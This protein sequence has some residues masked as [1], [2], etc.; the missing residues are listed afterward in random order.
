[1][2]DTYP[3]SPETVRQFSNYKLFD[4]VTPINVD[5]LAYL[6][7]ASDYDSVETEFL[8]DGF[9]QGFKLG[10]QGPRDFRRD[11]HNLRFRV[12]NKY[13]LWDKIMT[14]VQ[15]KRY[16]GP[17]DSPQQIFPDCYSVN[18]C[19]LVSKSGNRT[20]LINHYSYPPGNS[21]NDFIPDSYSKVTYQDFQEAITISL[22]LLKLGTA[23]NPVDLHYT[24]TDAK[25]V[26]RVLPIFWDDRRFQLLKAENP[27]SGKMQYFVD[28]CCGFGSSSSC[29][30]YSKISSCLRHLY[31]HQAG[32]D[33]VVYLDDGLQIG[34]NRTNAN[35]NLGIYLGICKEINLPISKEKTE[36]ATK[37]IKF[38]GLLINAIKNTVEVPADKVLKALN[39]IDQIVESKKVTVLDMQKIT[40]LLYFFTRAIVP[41]RAFTRRLY[42]TFSGSQLK[43]YHH[44]RVT[45]EMKLD[46]G[47]WKGFL[48]QEG[49]VVR[50][51]VD[52]TQSTFLDIQLTSDAAKSHLLGYSTCLVEQQTKTVFFCYSQWEASLIETYDPSVQF[53]ELYALSVGVVLFAP[54]FKNLRVRIGCDNQAVVQMVNETTSSCKHC[55]IL[56]RLLTLTALNFNIALQVRYVKSKDNLLSDALSRLDYNRFKASLP[57]E[58]SL[59]R[60]LTP[61]PMLPVAKFFKNIKL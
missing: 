45:Q 35:E 36:M 4:I 27:S 43:Q 16:C 46:L 2:N 30:L 51:F 31:K 61:G 11:S 37:M 7:K 26:F 53:L 18:P 13:D 49:N 23:Q 57:N 22:E 44:L 12:G 60:L 33:C 21:V 42:A 32:V 10:Y 6:L 38:L 9:T 3:T 20:R 24:R 5:R 29:F 17:Y 55:M 54:K 34:I 19:G 39:H 41:G 47:L 1:M 58:F 28:L 40:G 59:R 8:I 15:E 56:I 48:R 52:F 50:P 14:E 25:N